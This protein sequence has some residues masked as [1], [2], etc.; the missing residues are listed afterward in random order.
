MI[1]GLIAAVA[2]SA[3]MLLERYLLNAKHLGWKKSMTMGFGLIFIFMLIGSPLFF[4]YSSLYLSNTNIAYLGIVVFLA[5]AFNSLFFFGLKHTKVNE[6]E[7]LI[8]TSWIFTIINAAI[9][10]PEER[11]VFYIILALIASLSV[12]GSHLKKHHLQMDKYALCILLSAFLISIHDLFVKKLLDVYDP[13]TF[14]FVRCGLCA[15]AFLFLFKK[16]ASG[17]S[18]SAFAFLTITT[19]VAIVRYVFMYWSYQ[20]WGLV[21]TSLLMCIAPAIILVGSHI[22]LGEKLQTKNIVSTVIIVGCIITALVF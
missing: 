10:F 17:I 4:S 7:P 1:G 12:L 19:V 8:L 9:V 2:N 22:F 13:F 3:E 5:I 20:V 11:N 6:A 14:Y 16:H 18:K 21:Y 15:V